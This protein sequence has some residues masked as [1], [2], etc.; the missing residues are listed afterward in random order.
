MELF[1]I[2]ELLLEL[3]FGYE[4]SGSHFWHFFVPFFQIET[5]SAPDYLMLENFHNF[6]F[7]PDV[8]GSFINAAEVQRAPN[9]WSECKRIV[10][11]NFLQLVLELH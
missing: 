8:N 1:E 6:E 9:N 4:I 2:E 5:A 10:R 3:N 11:V 7:N